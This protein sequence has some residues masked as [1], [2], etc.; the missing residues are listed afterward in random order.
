MVRS[1]LFAAV[2]LPVLCL[3]L[4]GCPADEH[5]PGDL[6]VFAGI[7][8]VW[9]PS[10][11]FYMGQVDDGLAHTEIEEPRV[12]VILDKGFWM[13]KY[14]ITQKQW[15]DVMGNNPSE[16]K[17][18]N[19]PVETV[20]WDDAHSFIDTLNTAHPGMSFRLPSESEW[21]YACRAGTTTRYYWGDDPDMSEVTDHAWYIEN[22]DMVTHDVGQKL[23]N[24][25][26]LC[27]MNG[28]VWE[29][30]QDWW[31]DDYTGAPTDGSA[32]E[33]PAV[34][35]EHN[36]VT[37]GASFKYEDYHCQS[38]VRGIRDHTGAGEDHGFRLAKF[39]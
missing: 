30:V 31:H 24:A 25:W 22:S 19:R 23:P 13:S 4:I 39:D 28:N 37:R 20:T 2:L 21:E 12:L 33:T 35:L 16:F 10:G 8:F 6:A 27:D 9:C 15:Q 7:E 38:S 36:R 34:G 3:C 26:G 14:E 1:L 17:G 18:D 11:W 29:W 32:W 5:D